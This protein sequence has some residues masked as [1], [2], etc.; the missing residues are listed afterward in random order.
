MLLLEIGSGAVTEVVT[1]FGRRGKPAEAV[2]R[3]A[4]VAARRYLDAEGPVG[5][6]LADQLLVPLALADSGRFVCPPPTAHFATNLDVIRRFLD[7]E[8]SV[9]ALASKRVRVEVRR[10][11]GPR[12]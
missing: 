12:A 9:V 4:V 11:Q 6:H 7:V 1:G 3:D 8:V 5:G 10:R 2:A